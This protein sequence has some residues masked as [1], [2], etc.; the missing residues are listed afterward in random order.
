MIAY[1]NVFWRLRDAEE[2]AKE[3]SLRHPDEI[4]YVFGADI[5]PEPITV[6]NDA[7]VNEIGP[8]TE[9]MIC[10]FR[11]GEKTKIGFSG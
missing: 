9:F 10:Y 5:D 7:A 11:N 1:E 3:M 8:S 4:Y 6:Y 2:D